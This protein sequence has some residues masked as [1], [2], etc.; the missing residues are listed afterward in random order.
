MFIFFVLFWL[1]ISR[2][3][4]YREEK[5]QMEIEMQERSTNQN[6]EIQNKQKG[7]YKD[8]DARK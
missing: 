1:K 6:D 8:E 2:I 5:K 4:F 7:K 3:I